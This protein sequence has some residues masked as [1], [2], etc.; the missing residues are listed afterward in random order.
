M[1]QIKINQ[2]ALRK[3]A[4]KAMEKEAKKVAKRANAIA[5]TTDPAATEPYYEIDDKGREVRVQTTSS[6]GMNRRAAWHEATTQAL[7]RSLS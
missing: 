7:Q 1:A 6:P 4:K 5:S 2:A 3:L